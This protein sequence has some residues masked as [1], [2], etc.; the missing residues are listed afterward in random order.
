MWRDR[1]QHAQ[2]N[3]LGFAPFGTS[4]YARFTRLI[5]IVQQFHQRRDDGVELELLK[6]TRHALQGLVYFTAQI[7]FHFIGGRS[8][9]SLI[10]E[11]SPHTA[12]PTR[13]SFDALRVPRSAHFPTRKEHDVRAYGI[14]A[15]SADQHIRRDHVAAAL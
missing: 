11:Q 1:S 3:I 8:G 2:V 13:A 15:V 5:H 6:V 14:R 9:R 10:R 7:L 4:G 12:N